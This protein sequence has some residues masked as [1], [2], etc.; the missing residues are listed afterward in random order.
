MTA[1]K[2]YSK[3]TTENFIRNQVRGV[4]LHSNKLIE[5]YQ[6]KEDLWFEELVE[7]IFGDMN[8]NRYLDRIELMIKNRKLN[9]KMMLQEI[10][11]SDYDPDITQSIDVIYRVM[12]YEKLKKEISLTLKKYSIN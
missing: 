3:T 5:I 9:S 2:K 11:S 6:K 4:K 10:L 8:T 7:S 1:S 12:V